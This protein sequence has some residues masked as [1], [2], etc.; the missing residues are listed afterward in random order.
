MLSALWWVLYAGRNFYG[1]TDLKD[2]IS[3][4]LYC[5]KHVQ[6]SGGI[7]HQLFSLKMKSGGHG[8]IV[9]GGGGLS[10]LLGAKN[11]IITSNA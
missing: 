11:H 10:S 6:T 2:K 8:S 1:K 3:F 7:I 4:G 5:L 9:W